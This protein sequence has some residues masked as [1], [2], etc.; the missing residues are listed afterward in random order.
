MDRNRRSGNPLNMLFMAMSLF[1][2]LR[3]AGILDGAGGMHFDR[4]PVGTGGLIAAMCFVHFFPTSTDRALP[5][6]QLSQIEPNCVHAGDVWFGG[7]FR[8]LVTAAFVHVDDFHLYYNM[9][10]LL[11]KGLHLENRMSTPKYLL[12]CAV[13]TVMSH[14][15]IVLVAVGLWRIFDYGYYMNECAVGASAV[16]F[17]LKTILN[18][19]S[20]PNEVTILN[21]F[22]IPTKYAVWA[23]LI[24]IQL[25]SRNT[26]FIGHLCG[27]LAG[28]IYYSFRDGIPTMSSFAHDASSI[29]GLSLLVAPLGYLRSLFGTAPSSSSSSSSSSDYHFSAPS[30]P[31]RRRG[32]ADNADDNNSG[33]LGP[34]S[35]QGYRLGAGAGRRLGSGN[36]NPQGGSNR[37]GIRSPSS[38]SRSSHP[39]GSVEDRLAD[40]LKQMGFRNEPENRRALRR[41]NMDIDAVVAELL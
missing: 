2:N 20:D 10:S 17:A 18:L 29:P 21:G 6:L 37:G 33:N 22:A 40:K 41:H 7:E 13:L 24:L 5:Q 23:E 39:S 12:M 15:L 30:A 28:L 16:I 32:N 14:G 19:Q 27:I 35:G 26:S 11:W 31:Q 3:S 38:S 8:R 4:I 1:Q 9:V 36:E 34:F 25:L